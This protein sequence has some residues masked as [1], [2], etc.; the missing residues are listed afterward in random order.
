VFAKGSSKGLSI[1][2]LSQD[3]V[4]KASGL[5]NLTKKLKWAVPIVTLL[6]AAAAVAISVRRRKTLMR[7]TVGGAMGIVVFLVGLR[8]LHRT[9]VSGAVKEGFNGQVSSIVFDT[10]LRYLKDGLWLVLWILIAAAIVEWVV[11]PARYAVALRH[12]VARAWGWTVNAVKQATSK[13]SRSAASAGSVRTAGWVREHQSGLRMIG[14]V[15]VG[16]FFVLSGNIT[17]GGALIALLILAAY[18]G[19]L[20]LLIMWAGKIDAG[21]PTSAPTTSEQPTS[22]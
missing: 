3:Q 16:L 2:I 12:Q 10:L 15:V 14:A 17:F 7:A 22:V 19:L 8:L 5:F 11:G 1:S 21:P 4:S 6:L 13:E 20:Q 18:F 9:F